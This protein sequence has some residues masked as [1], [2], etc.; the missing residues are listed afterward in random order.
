MDKSDT[1]FQIGPDTKIGA[2]LDK[3]PQLENTLLEMAPQFKQLRNP[4]LRKTV[5]RIASLSQ[6]AAIGKVSLTEMVNALRTEA[7]IQEVFAAN[8]DVDVTSAEAPAWFK[9]AQI[10]KT[11][12]ARPLLEAGEHPVQR[13]LQET[14]ALDPGKIYELITPF[15]PAPLIEAVQKQGLQAWSS[16]VEPAVFHTYFF[17][18]ASPGK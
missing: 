3:Y 4:I 12:D 18:G 13:V 17:L 1:E 14:K 9:P 11:L 10:V 15:L 16:E 7:G 8:V 6:A 2:L 5:G